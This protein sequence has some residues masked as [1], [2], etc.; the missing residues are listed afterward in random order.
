MTILPKGQ[1]AGEDNESKMIKAES[2]MNAYFFDYTAKTPGQPMVSRA[3][4]ASAH[5]T[6]HC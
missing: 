5:L 2:K 1:I 4:I 6:K 3:H